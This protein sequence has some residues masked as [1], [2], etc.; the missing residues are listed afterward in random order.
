M[1]RWP[2]RLTD[3]RVVASVVIDSIPAPVEAGWAFD[4]IVTIER[5]QRAPEGVSADLWEGAFPARLISRNAEVRPHAGERWRLLLSLRAPRG[6]A[7]PGGADFERTLFRDGVQALGTVVGSNLN[8]VLDDG[9]RPLTRWREQISAHIDA[10]VTDRDASA[11]IGA[12]A[13]GD[14][15]RVSR[16]Q[17]RVFNATGT[18]HLVA[19]SGMHVTLFAVIMFAVARRVW[20]ACVTV[21]AA[22]AGF[23]RSVRW[24]GCKVAS[25]PRETFAAVFGFL[26]AAG[27]AALAGLS[28]PTER[29]LIMLGV[30][31]LARSSA[32][33]SHPF[34][35]FAWALLL[36]LLV[37]PFAP[38]SAGFWLSFAAMAAII[39][40]ASGRSVRPARWREALSV[41]LV[42]SIALLPFTLALFGS[43]PLIGVPVNLLAIPAMSWVLVPTVL[44]AVALLP[45]STFASD[46]V[47]G[48]AEWLHN[49]GW[50]WLAAASDTPWALIHA[51][52]PWWWYALA[53]CALALAAMPWPLLMRLAPLICIAPLA[54]SIERPVK[55]GSA[56]ITA[57]DVGEGS[58]VVVRTARHT[59]VYGTGD[60]YGT[61]GRVADRVVVPFLRSSG[62]HAIDRLVI[63]RSS[64]AAGTGVV[65][66]LAEMPI[67]QILVGDPAHAADAS[68]IDCASVPGSWTWDGVT[69]VLGEPD[70]GGHAC[71]LAVRT[72]AEGE[73]RLL[74][75][76]DVM[77]VESAPRVD[78]LSDLQ[79]VSRLVRPGVDR[80]D[81]LDSSANIEP[82]EATRP[83]EPSPHRWLVVSS[84]RAQRS[85]EKYARNHPELQGA[86]VLASAD[87]GAIRVPLDSARG[88]ATP[89]AYRAHRRTLWSAAP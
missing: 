60:S 31:L 43:V 30:W 3:E 62:V 77:V 57:L 56:E 44:L 89:E 76:P 47:L 82:V 52:P 9:H 20:A 54:A 32:R 19:I 6:R 87:L 29:T 42:V 17:W 88:P 10:R 22:R 40:S 61:N 59:L 5:P 35:A 65:A 63:P 13:V 8:A 78:D 11:L 34:Q 72:A 26:A 7:N 45:V 74:G 79:D 15:G 18:T 53:A 39:L 38:L 28:V 41:Q 66:L 58:A 27:Y 21:E 46:A 33:A 80:V 50:P 2:E 55:E 36:V 1:H 37:D 84:R 25:V 14:T 48:L 49:L 23:P 73:V 71:A 83:I 67:G 24:L 86:G 12:L 64:P 51:S 70:D 4:G 75:E 85:L 16:E 69:F 81:T 68:T